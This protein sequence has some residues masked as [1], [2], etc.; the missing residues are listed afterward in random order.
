MSERWAKMFEHIAHVDASL[1]NASRAAG[2]LERL[3]ADDSGSVLMEREM[4]ELATE[5]AT[6][7]AR[8]ARLN[9]QRRRALLI[10]GPACHPNREV[11]R[12]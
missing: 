4:R 8:I 6:R 3:A 1:A 11:R 2:S 5:I 7:T 12:G 10:D 9:D